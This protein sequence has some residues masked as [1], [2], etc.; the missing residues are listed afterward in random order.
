[1]GGGSRGCERG[2]VVGRGKRRVGLL[3]SVSARRTALV[4]A[5]LTAIA[6][7]C[8]GIALPAAWAVEAAAIVRVPAHAQ[9]LSVTPADGA[10]LTQPPA[11]VALVFNEEINPAFVTVT[12]TTG[13]ASSPLGAP[14]VSGGTVTVPVPSG[15]AAGA[16]RIAYRVVSKDGHPISG[17]SGFTVAAATSSAAVQ[18]PP[19]PT[20]APPT[21][22]APAAVATTPVALQPA[23]A[24]SSVP[25]LLTVAAAVLALAAGAGVIVWRRRQDTG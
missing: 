7:A 23:A 20:T 3:E 21:G 24:P 9:L 13:G 6:F 12:L 16:Y 4:A 17:A 22:T 14:V 25:T 15:A 8:F 5:C 11:Q 18:S 19:V 10:T 1:M 2:E